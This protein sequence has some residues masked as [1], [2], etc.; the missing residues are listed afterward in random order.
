MYRGYASMRHTTDMGQMHKQN[1]KERHAAHL[2]GE[3]L[4]VEFLAICLQLRLDALCRLCLRFEAPGL[5]RYDCSK[6]KGVFARESVSSRHVQS[7]S[8]N[9]ATDT[10]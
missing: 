10:N 2:T 3:Q 6:V 7:V 4:L 5:I 9:L 8:A 1:K